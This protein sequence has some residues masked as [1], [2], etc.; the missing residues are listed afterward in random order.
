MGILEDV[1]RK[2]RPRP[3]SYQTLISRRIGKWVAAGI[4]AGGAALFGL[5][6]NKSESVKHHEQPAAVVS[7]SQNDENYSILS[8]IA[9]KKPATFAEAKNVKVV[10]LMRADN[11]GARHQRWIVQ[12]NDGTTLR[13]VYNVD[14]SEKVPLSPGDVISMGGELAFDERT[15]EPLLHWLHQDPSKKHI[16]GYV[17]HDGKTYGLIPRDSKLSKKGSKYE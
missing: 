7:V 12:F 2:K 15:K 9:Q 1:L 3:P 10:R 16:D 5:G 17:L 13:G 11:R 4:I 14:L 6:K 8:L